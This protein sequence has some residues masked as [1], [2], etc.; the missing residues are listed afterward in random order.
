[1][2]ISCELTDFFSDSKLVELI[3]I[4]KSSSDVLDLLKPRENQHSDVLAWCFN[5]KEG[6]GQGDAILKDFLTAV[7][8]SST[9]KIPGD[10]ISGR[11]PRDLA[12]RHIAIL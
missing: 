6:H 2:S 7:Y 3:E 1:M 4:T 10:R 11:N 8:I 5:S 12:F 9:D